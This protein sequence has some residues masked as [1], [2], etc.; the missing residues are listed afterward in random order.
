MRAPPKNGNGFLELGE[1]LFKYRQIV[2]NRD[3]PC[4]L[5]QYRYLNLRDLLHQ[6]RQPLRGFPTATCRPWLVAIRCS[7][8]RRV[9]HGRN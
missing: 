6:F 7:H 2:I 8:A 4:R 9:S 1:G 3:N 5:I